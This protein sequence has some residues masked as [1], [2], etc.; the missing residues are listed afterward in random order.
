MEK[1]LA[2]FKHCNVELT[3]EHFKSIEVRERD[4]KKSLYI[5]IKYDE[6]IRKNLCKMIENRRE[7]ERTLK[8][9]IVFDE[10]QLTVMDSFY[11]RVFYTLQRIVLAFHFA[12]L[13]GAILDFCIDICKKIKTK[14]T[15]IK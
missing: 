2:I 10:L 1:I 12:M 13:V 5:V 3:K 7:I 4:N 9:L 6:K 15:K 11:K 14:K 8:E